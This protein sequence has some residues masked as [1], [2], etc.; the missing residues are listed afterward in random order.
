MFLHG[1]HIN[2]RAL[3]PSDAE[4]LYDWENKVD[5]WPLSF[6][7]VPFSRFI[8]EEFI[9]TA[10]QDIYTSKQLRLMVCDNQNGE[11]I[12]IL[13]FFDFE[14][15][16]AR[17]GLG[18]YIHAD[19][20]HRGAAFESIELAKTYCA[21]TLLLKQ[22]YAHVNLSNTASLA[23]FSKAGFEQ[24]GIKKAWSRTGL[25]TFEDVCFLQFIFPSE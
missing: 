21:N 11:V 7:Q 6:T 24:T 10:Y 19:F 18:I 2:L 23:L 12:G 22:I 4:L 5:I 16:H 13:D 17:C 25:N 9:N 3:E 20:R 15:Q 14:P 1:E 8:L